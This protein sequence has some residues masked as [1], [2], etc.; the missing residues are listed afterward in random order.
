MNYVAKYF[1]EI[2]GANKCSPYH[3]PFNQM[4][5]LVNSVSCGFAFDKDVVN[6]EVQHQCMRQNQAASGED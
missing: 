1:S 3:F 4:T 6:T 5:R 2:L